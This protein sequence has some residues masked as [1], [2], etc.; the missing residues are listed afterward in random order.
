[1]SKKHN[2]KGENEYIRQNERFLVKRTAFVKNIGEIHKNGSQ[3]NKN[4]GD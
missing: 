3:P 1:M 2:I 4:V